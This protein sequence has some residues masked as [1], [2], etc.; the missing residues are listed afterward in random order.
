MYIASSE[1][2]TVIICVCDI[3]LSQASVYSHVYIISPPQRSAD[4]I[5]T[6]G[7][8]PD[9]SQ[10]PV[11]LLVNSRSLALIGIASQ[12]TVILPGGFINCASGA[13]STVITC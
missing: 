3:G 10:T 12:D 6:A 5:S 9:I 1:G 11:S 8:L 2:S 4:P 7:T 13:G